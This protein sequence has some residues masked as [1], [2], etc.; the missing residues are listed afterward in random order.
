MVV[1]PCDKVQGFL[2]EMLSGYTQKIINLEGNNFDFNQNPW[3]HCLTQRPSF[4]RLLNPGIDNIYVSSPEDT[5]LFKGIG[6]GK[7]N[8][9]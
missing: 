6:D 3:R 2:P 1:S 4:S 8:G 9:G 5:G 7:G